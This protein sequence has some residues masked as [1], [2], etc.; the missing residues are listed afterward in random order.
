MSQRLGIALLSIALCGAAHSQTEAPPLGSRIDAYLAPFVERGE[1]SGNLLIAQGGEVVYE[2]SFGM[3]DRE[4]G[5]PN[6]PETRFNIASVTKPMTVIALISLASEGKLSL[7]DKLSKW[8]PDFPRGE[9]ITI[10][11]IARHRSGIAHRVTEPH[12]ET[13]PRTAA[14]MVAFAAKRPLTQEPG[15]EYNYSS[16]GFS[17]LARVLELASGKDYD[18][19]LQERVF[20]PAGVA[21]T[22][23]VDS[24]TIFPHRAS[25]YLADGRGGALN[26]QLRDYSYLVGAGSVWSTARDL[27][28]LIDAVRAGKMPAGVQESFIDENGLDWNGVT[29][30]FRA[31]A[32]WH[33]AS[34]AT[35]V[36]LGNLQSGAANRMR[37][38][39]PKIL[40]GEE[41]AVPSIP[42]MR[43]I[44]VPTSVL[45]R[46][47]GL[48]QLRP[49]S[50]LRVF[51]DHGVL[52][53]NE[54]ILLPIGERRFFC[55]QDY[56]T[57][58]VVLDEA[59]KPTRLDWSFGEEAF[60]CP[61]IGD[62]VEK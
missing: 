18:A 13:V 3:A 60:P 59:G 57:V 5:V 52:N 33:R 2:R 10:G 26:A 22:A 21:D 32:D 31:F 30:G 35:I 25:G 56:A 17:V 19:L 39:L 12:E 43:P 42:G 36:F 23:H 46:Y 7:D 47:E 53:V 45:R 55:P 1:L 4:L 40:S 58:E 24:R 41:V 37:S 49:G 14:E 29:G 38:D 48:Y 27:R 51:V 11:Q 6:G 16:G 44:E 9:E 34:D 61:R 8:I 28:A 15:G 54:W 50:P 62:L 20:K